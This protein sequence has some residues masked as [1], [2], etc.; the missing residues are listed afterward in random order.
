MSLN[1]NNSDNKE[2][3]ISRNTYRDLSCL[4]T[5][6]SILNSGVLCE[7]EANFSEQVLITAISQPIK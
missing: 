3:I 2:L 7:V 6:A 1:K 4:K 5:F